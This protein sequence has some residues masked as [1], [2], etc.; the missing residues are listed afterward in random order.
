MGQRNPSPGTSSQ[1]LQRPTNN[2]KK[3]SNR[4]KHSKDRE[5]QSS[6]DPQQ[7]QKS[8]RKVNPIHQTRSSQENNNSHHVKSSPSNNSSR[9]HGTS[10]SNK[11]RGTSNH[12]G[13]REQHTCSDTVHKDTVGRNKV[14]TIHRPGHSGE[15][16]NQSFYQ[17]TSKMLQMPE[18]LPY[19]K[20]MPR[21]TRHL[22]PMR[23]P[24]QNQHLCGQT[25]SR[26]RSYTQVQ[27][28]QGRSL[29]GQCEVP[30]PQRDYPEDETNST[31]PANRNSTASQVS[32]D[33][34]Y[35]SRQTVNTP[36]TPSIS[37][38][39]PHVTTDANHGRL[40][41][42]ITSSR[43]Q[44]KEESDRSNTQVSTSTTQSDS[45]YA[46]R[47]RGTDTTEET[48]PLRRMEADHTETNEQSKHKCTSP[49]T[50][51]PQTCRNTS[52]TATVNKSTTPPQQPT[53][54]TQQ[55]NT[56]RVS[57]DGQRYS[58]NESAHHDNAA[59]A[60]EPDGRHPT[61]Q[62]HSQ[63]N[64]SH[65][66]EHVRDNTEIRIL[67]WNVQGLNSSEKQSALVAAIELDNID[68]LMLQDSRISTRNDGKP[69]IRVP[70]CHTYS[71]PASAECH[72]LITIVRNNIPSMLPPPIA[73]SEG[74]ELLTVK[75]WINK[76]PT[77][78][79]NI[80][81][82]RGET[83]FRDILACRLPSILAGDFNAHH[84]MWGR[85]TDRAGRIL[86]DQIENANAYVILNKPHTPTTQ[87]DTTIDLTIV[88]A[89]LAAISNWSIYENLISDH[90]PIMLTLQTENAPQ[91][92]ISTPK[93]CLHKAAWSSFKT[94]L[95][96]LSTTINIH[97][98]IDEHAKGITD[99]LLQAAEGSIPKTKPN[100]KKRNYWCYNNEVKMAKW[101]LN[102]ALKKLRNKKRSDYPNL[103][104]Y[105]QKV[106]EAN[107]QYKET[108]SKSRN[109]AWDEWLTKNN[110]ELNSKKLWQ[111]IKRCTGINQQTPAHQNPQQESNIIL[112]EFVDRC[113]SHQLPDEDI[114]A[115]QQQKPIR[116]QLIQDAI[117]SPS[118]CDRPITISEI[119]NVLK[120]V[121]DSAPGEDMIAY[122]MLKKAPPEYIH[123]LASLYTRS[124]Q[125]GKLPAVWK[126]ATIIPIPKKNKSYRPIS[127]LSV[128]GKVMEKIILHRIRWSVIP[129]NVRATGFK[130]RSG[131]RDAISILLHDISISR[132]RRRRAAAVYIDLQKAFELVNKEVLLSE[133]TTAGLQGN[134]LAWTSDFLSHRRA[135]VRFQNCC[136]NPQSFENGTPQG[137]SLS[138]TLFNYAMNIFLRLQLPEGVRILAYADDLVIYCVDRQ[139]IIQRLQSALDIMTD[140]A[141]NNG[142][143]FAPEK[144]VATWFYRP[145]PDT[146]LQLY[147]NDINWEDRV[148]YLGVSIDK[149][150]NMNSHVT[151]TIN[152]VSRSLNTIKVMA[153]L[154]GVN[155]NI[156]L[157]TFNSCTRACLDYGAECFNMF[158]L[159][160]MRRLQRKQNNGLKLVLGVN[161]WAPTSNIHAELRILPIANRVEV[162]QANMINKIMINQNHPAT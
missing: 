155:S 136:S 25:E 76:R 63:H 102:R 147:N 22:R 145:N 114:R 106:R 28:L 148:K 133:L 47:V 123:Q 41:R 82:V 58:S 92:T 141:S 153:S 88:H 2:K 140:T 130:P 66:T 54:S 110:T 9:C 39:I 152:S 109:K 77:L 74:T 65:L 159:T 59:T 31:N 103:E 157:R 112:T 35:S 94:K 97:G 10:T 19:S 101:S 18:V 144:T 84:K 75:V 8:L 95:I 134:I 142:F 43:G 17:R 119:E 122:S 67:H 11:G 72:G 64:E 156:L 138:P 91:V 93:W 38:Q 158:N 30:V 50:A 44:N 139:N 105:Q 23:R 107:I 32:V 55:H 96:E 15:V 116:Q 99:I 40:P 131:T 20:Y 120:N 68:V 111:R 46:T 6:G 87:Y 150:L 113:A 121:R 80:Y 104:P 161:K 37:E 128:I 5:P 78:L 24:T 14:A 90:F 4:K 126:L 33:S 69:P 86:L 162:F 85:S 71:I 1:E 118:E 73:T 42:Y 149:H 127:L 100:K 45:Q 79:H 125:E 52:G 12:M 98:S 117:N 60:N 137:S 89:S 57:D 146:K 115:L 135:R 7:H 21:K 151:Q 83:D 27:Q 16:R 53:S 129:P 81:R 132:T 29:Y 34:P 13:Q 51:T 62:V 26:R 48:Q 70:N 3:I 61:K 108:C 154:S 49:Q 56:S 36:N 124:L 143:R 160:Q